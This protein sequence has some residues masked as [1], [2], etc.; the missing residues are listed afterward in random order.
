MGL[1]YRI[2]FTC[3][4]PANL[5][6]LLRSTPCFADY[7]SKH[8]LYNFRTNENETPA[9]MP[10]AYVAVMPDGIIFC[11]CCGREANIIFGTV[12]HRLVS[13]FGKLEIDEE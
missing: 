1:E 11:N 6:R 8:G 4:S 3:D 10:S 7:D 13:L 12:L 9:Q 2:K 5:D